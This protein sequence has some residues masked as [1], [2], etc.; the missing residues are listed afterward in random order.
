MAALVDSMSATEVPVTLVNLDQTEARTVVVQDGAYGE[1]R[2]GQA[3][4]GPARATV[5]RPYVRVRLEPGCGER[6]VL[7]QARYAEQPAFAFPWERA[8]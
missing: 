5:D 3:A 4:A 8:E 7:E 1:Q 2:F 6:I